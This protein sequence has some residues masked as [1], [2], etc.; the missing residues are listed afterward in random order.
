MIRVREKNSNPEK[1]LKKNEER[2]WGR[3][4][5]NDEDGDNQVSALPRG[6]GHPVWKW[7][8]WRLRRRSGRWPN[9]S[10]PDGTS[11]SGFFRP[12]ESPMS[13]SLTNHE[14]RSWMGEFGWEWMK[15][16]LSVPL[17]KPYDVVRFSDRARSWAREEPKLEDPAK[18][19][20]RPH[21]E[22][23]CGSEMS[24]TFGCW[25]AGCTA[26]SGCRRLNRVLYS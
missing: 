21:T 6:T 15:E 8:S 2:G 26:W 24:P 19:D 13:I 18:V 1:S 22:S 12:A 4:C 20:C 9:I 7:Q 11:G 3:G 14:S 16:N 5:D 23:F 17:P 10:G 25:P